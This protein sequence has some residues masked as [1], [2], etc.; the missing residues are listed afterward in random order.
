MLTIEV[1]GF[2]G[3]GCVRWAIPTGLTVLVGPNQSGR[4]T[5]FRA[6]RFLQEWSTGGD[7]TRA[8][9]AAPRERY[10][11][12]RITLETATDRLSV[13]LEYASIGGWAI[14]GGSQRGD[15]A[16]VRQMLQASLLPPLPTGPGSPWPW[17][18]EQRTR[19]ALPRL[20]EHVP[21]EAIEHEL[22]VDRPECAIGRAILAASALGAWQCERADTP[23]ALI[24]LDGVFD[25]LHPSAC[26]AAVADL[27]EL[28]R[29]RDAYAILVTSSP[30]ALRAMQADPSRVSSMRRVGKWWR[31]RAITED[32]DPS[33][34][35]QIDLAAYYMSGELDRAAQLSG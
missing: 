8:R 25:G 28:A 23:G 19:Q 29:A 11:M 13:Q 12:G 9:L 22:D 2:Y 15:G 3:L 31:P 27:D 30:V 33:W 16:Q 34:Y 10:S 26:L 35:A 32:Q 17:L 14:I 21:I 7:R 6:L 1:D 24:G 20:F 5:L 4:T 18:V